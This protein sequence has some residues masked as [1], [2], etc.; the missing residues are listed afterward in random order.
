MDIKHVDLVLALKRNETDRR[1]FQCRNQG[2]L[3]RKPVSK[4][5]DIVCDGR[6]G[7]LLR[8]G[9]IVARQFFYAVPENLAQQGRVCR[10]ERPKG[11]VRVRNRHHRATFHCVLP[12]LVSSSSTPIAL[13]SSRMRS[14]SLKF[15]AFRA[16]FRDS[17]RLTTL[18]SSTAADA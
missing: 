4:L 8:F 6:P 15:F 13:S 18:I 3:P 16:L 9:I 1:A 12:S 17:I 7:L 10:K 14:A 2:Q 11:K 5:F